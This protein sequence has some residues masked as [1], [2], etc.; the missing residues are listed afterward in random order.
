MEATLRIF[1]TGASG[2]IGS[3]VVRA[4]LNSR[5]EVLCLVSPLDNLR[6]LDNVTN[7]IEIIRGNLKR[8]ADFKYELQ[9]WKPQTC[10]HLAWY[11]EP[12]EY[13]HSPENL[14]SLQGSL[15]LLRELAACNCEQFIGAGT[16]AEYQMKTEKLSES[17]QTDPETLY[18][19]SKL[20]FQLIGEQI[21]KRSKI[22]FAWARIFYLYGPHED[23]R[24]LVPSAILKLQ[25]GEVFSSSPGEQVRDY[26]Y[27]TDVANAFL[28]LVTYQA[29][30][31]YNI[32]SAEPVT[33]RGLLST[34]GNLMDKSKLLAHGALPYREWEPR[35]IS[36]DN[37]RLKAI[38]WRP[39]VHLLTGLRDT[40]NWWKTQLKK[41]E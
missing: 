15:D 6:R 38:G 7:Q 39:R 11:T 12:N 3:H 25:R 21:A 22:R 19:A 26:L 27:V 34:I 14:C 29:T 33:I 10:I 41:E 16:C 2:F 1:V 13:L 23:S 5:H 32:S 40:I 37:N 31:I 17:D 8:V 30:G 9:F 18:A 4:L 20:S 24:R 28:A 36:G 35:F